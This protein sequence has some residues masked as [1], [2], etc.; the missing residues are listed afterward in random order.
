[1]E[2]ENKPAFIFINLQENNFLVE[3]YSS[4]K[5]GWK[6]RTYK[7][8]YILDY[9]IN[10]GYT[11]FNYIISENTDINET[12]SNCDIVYKK[13]NLVGKVINIFDS[14]QI[15]TTD[16]LIVYFH[17]YD[18]YLYGKSIDCKKICMSNHFIRVTEK[19]DLALDGYDAFV[20]EV[21]L[22]KN[23]FVNYYFNVKNVQTII[24][25][26]I[27][28]ERFEIRKEF[29]NR[30]NKAMAIGTLSTCEGIPEYEGYRTFFKTEWIQPMRLEIFKNK[31]KLK[32]IDSY[33]S[34]IY[35]GLMR[36]KKTDNI[37]VKIFKKIYNKFHKQQ[38]KYT[39]F[40]MVD[41]FNEYNMFI[42]P[43]ELVGMPGIGFVE[44]MACGTAYIGLDHPM[45]R[46]LGLIPGVHYITYDGTLKNLESV[47][48]YYQNHLV[49]LEKIAK[50]GSE[51][52]RLNFNT[53]VVA[54]KFINQLLQ[55]ER[56]KTNEA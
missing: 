41:K 2:Q 9:L 3:A 30:K 55:L 15:K 16:I 52:V 1:M 19:H 53:Q 36:I 21:D 7:H 24:C 45:Y 31:N 40:D 32:N 34:Y 49:E 23:D 17:F 27:F 4:I 51:Y 56:K 28:A 38:S 44:G 14:T 54:E 18:Q 47:V 13:N 50:T 5:N 33:I 20:S 42:C 26:Y 22:S 29:V 39:S 12:I 48:E 46:C 43:E 37:F 6:V 25:P 35:Q 8:R 10:K 11:I